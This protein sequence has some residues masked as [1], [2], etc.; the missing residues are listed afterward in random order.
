MQGETES[1]VNNSLLTELLDLPSSCAWFDPTKIHNIEM[2]SLPEFFNGLSESKTPEIYQ[3]YRNFIINA[4]RLSPQNY[5]TPTSCRRCLAGDVCSIL[6]VHSFLERWEIINNRV[7]EDSRPAVVGPPC[8]SHF[9]VS[10]DTPRGLNK[11][12]GPAVDDISYRQ[13]KVASRAKPKFI[14]DLLRA[15]LDIY[16]T[17]TILRCKFCERSFSVRE[18]F[19]SQNLAV[20]VCRTCHESGDFA[21]Q[22]FR[23][24]ALEERAS[25]WSDSE[26]LRLLEGIEMFGDDWNKVA[27][28]V[29]TRNRDECISYF[30]RLPIQESF[31]EEKQRNGDVNNVVQLQHADVMPFL[32]QAF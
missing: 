3:T 27:D 22:D 26:V 9:A 2:E 31:E 24:L 6:R 4:Y 20:D 28:H 13:E 10:A 7:S 30:I 8:T 14:K 23:P 1:L 11:L 16:N 32:V 17:E 25:D 19:R 15:R 29:D 18:M 12:T 5:L 21:N